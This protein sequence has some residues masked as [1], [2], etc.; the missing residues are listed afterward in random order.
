MDEDFDE[1]GNYIPQEY[2]ESEPDVSRSDV[3]EAWEDEQTKIIDVQVE[4]YQQDT[5]DISKS[6]LPKDNSSGPESVP[7]SSAPEN[8]LYQS[9]LMQIPELIRNVAVCGPCR[10][11][12]T[13]LLSLLNCN[14]SLGT[15]E[16]QRN[17]TIYPKF[18]SFLTRT[19]EY[20]SFVFNFVDTPGH[21]DFMD[22]K[23]RCLN[24]SD[25]QLYVIDVVEGRFPLS[26]IDRR[27]PTIIVVNKLDRLL[28][29]LRLPPKQASLRI[30]ALIQELEANIEDVVFMSAKFQFS[31]T[32][33]SMRNLYT[34]YSVNV[35]ALNEIST[36]TDYIMEPIY[37]LVS[38]GMI[39]NRPEAVVLLQSLGIK[40][41]TK[42]WKSEYDDRIRLILKRYFEFEN[43]MQPLV[44]KIVEFLPSPKLSPRIELSTQLV[45]NYNNKLFSIRKSHD[46]VSSSDIHFPITG[47]L[48][49]KIESSYPGCW[50][51]TPYEGEIITTN[52]E[53][54]VKV[55][56]E[57]I[58]VNEES[59]TSLIHSLNRLSLIFP[60]L[61][62]TTE[63]NG[64]VMLKGLGEL[65]LDCVLFELKQLH[66]Y[67]IKVGRPFP[68][69][70][71]TVHSNSNCTYP[72]SSDNGNFEVLVSAAPLGKDNKDHVTGALIS[73]YNGN[74][75]FFS[76]HN[77]ESLENLI[78]SKSIE[79]VIS[80]FQWCCAQGPL[81]EEPLLNVQFS[82]QEIKCSA[83][84]SQ[85]LPT[86]R[87]ACYA[88]VISAGA[89]IMEPYNKL[90]CISSLAG[91]KAVYKEVEKRSGEII[92]DSPVEGTNL[93]II[94]SLVPTVDIFG[95]SVDIMCHMDVRDQ[96][97]IAIEFSDWRCIDSDPLDISQRV[98]KLKPSEATSY[99]RDIMLKTR[100]RKGLYGDV[101][102]KNY[103]DTSVQELFYEQ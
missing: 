102:L 53:P 52:I 20:K 73:S 26:N 82:I 58:A 101:N 18:Y 5:Q 66:D 60:S 85:I 84:T 13:S 16:L 46:S 48:N 64:D 39:G 10:Q 75:L 12:K 6:L 31:F 91:G 40:V 8:W 47:N 67:K 21:E 68:Q 28:T 41:S 15:I 34:R 23:D 4:H 17:I 36:F 50:Y 29:E 57:N 83:N 92:S 96:S 7:E 76:G 44:E 95:L 81:L 42:E 90:S 71:E 54:Y 30:F 61:D 98:E 72:T 74:I 24:L 59:T 99:A 78:D 32:L 93:Y 43:V 51:L 14:S 65:Y 56:I 94:E 49:I 62:F 27:V 19:V 88:A 11:G 87:R 22:F 55:G 45:I 63:D 70:Y 2:S 38:C 37:K 69:Y 80:G 35:P 89:R 1:F 103:L 97:R 79:A 9:G 25:G 3:S 33:K 100:K 86:M 77:N